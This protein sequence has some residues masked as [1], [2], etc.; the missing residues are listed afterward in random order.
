[1]SKTKLNKFLAS[2]VL[3]GNFIVLN[4]VKKIATGKYIV[5]DSSGLGVLLLDEEGD[6]HTLLLLHAQCKCTYSSVGGMGCGVVE[7]AL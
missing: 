7:R 4:V 6:Q 2:G 3:K 1:M 5:G